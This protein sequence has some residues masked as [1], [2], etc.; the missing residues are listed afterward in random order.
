MK[1][2]LLSILLAACLLVVLLPAAAFAANFEAKD[3]TAG[4]NDG[5]TY[6]KLVDGNIETKW[7]VTDFKGAYI[8]FEA[9]E[10]MKVTGYSITTGNDN[11]YDPG[12]N[13]KDWTL[14]GS[15]ATEVPTRNSDS[16]E[17]IDCVTDDDTLKDLNHATYN[18]YLKN[19]TET[20]RYFKL[21]ITATQGS[22]VMQMSEFALSSCDH[23][24]GEPVVTDP[25]CTTKGYDS[26]TCTKCGNVKI[27]NEKLPLG[28]DFSGEDEKCTRCDKTRAELYTFD[29]SEGRVTITNDEYEGRLM[30]RYGDGQYE[31]Y[32]DPDEVITVIGSTTEGELHVG[33]TTPV[34][35]NIKDLVIDRSSGKWAYAMSL[36]AA[37]AN[38]TLILDGKNRIAGGTN[39]SGI[40]V[41]AD[42][43]L[44]IEGDGSLE[45]TGGIFAA[46]IGGS[47]DGDCGTIII[48]SG[49]VT[50]IGGSGGASIGTG[51]S[52]DNMNH[53]TLSGSGGAWITAESVRGDMTDFNGVLNDKVYGSVELKKDLTIPEG[54]SLTVT[55]GATLTIPEDVTL[56]VDGILTNDGTIIN[57]GTIVGTVTGNQPKTS[58]KYL[59]ENGSEKTA[60]C[61]VLTADNIGSYGT[62]NAGWYVVRDVVKTI[63]SSI[64]VS[65]DVHL[66]LEDRSDFNV[67]FGIRVKDDDSDVNNGSANALSIYAQSTGKNM[68]KLTAG[69]GTS[70][71]ASIGGSYAEN[72]GTITI[73][74]GTIAVTAVNGAGIGGGGGGETDIGG[75]GG[76]I[77]INGGNVTATSDTGAGIGG[78]GSEGGSGGSGGII[79][80]TGGVV[81]ATSNRGAGI[82]V[83]EDGIGGTFRTDD[84]NAVIFASSISDKTNQDSWSGVIFEGSEGKVYGASVTPDE[85]FTIE[86]GKNLFIPENAKLII[87][88]ITAVNKGCV[89]VD[90]TVSGL[91]GDLYYPLTV[92]G[93]TAGGDVSTYLNK[94]YGK[95]GG[96]ITLNVAP[97]KGYTLKTL[98]VT[99]GNNGVLS[100]TNTD[101]NEYAFTMPASKVTVKAV[102]AEIVNPFTD[103][104]SS[105]YYYDAVLWAVGNGITAGT[106]DTTFSPNNPCTRAQAVTLLWRAAGCPAPKNTKMTFTD[107]AKGSY[108]YDAVLW[109]VENRITYGTSDTTFSPNA[110]C[111]RAQFTSFLWRFE[112]MPEAGKTNPFTDVPKDAYY[113]DA[114]LWAAEKGITYGTSDTTFSPYEKCTRAQ[115]VTFMYRCMGE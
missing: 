102:F 57:N 34:K 67:E 30:V 92:S 108:Y 61:T 28:H 12:R 25:T 29:V 106:S 107:V 71:E 68:G 99:N 19:P 8:I 100:V 90:G 104:K 72:G 9:S 47:A 26:L 110:T 39:R 97:P 53:G 79:T 42:A 70:G 43:T 46:G 74:G 56:T 109:A 49:T 58:V 115:T 48:N 7:C 20:Y 14:Y 5:E 85:D 103:V 22:K 80:I 59:D 75:Y 31:K 81:T 95:A 15:A 13:P 64:T 111:N 87:K 101:K 44:T 91:G 112:G 63:S 76:T 10:A 73:N 78:G 2:R 88:D 21:E 66:I 62:L 77:T 54:E 69:T 17:E 18:Y 1:K 24:W 96:T 114:V 4:A 86:N 83:G 35:I 40:S 37:E 60:D 82:G 32:V 89:Y 16:W 51:A 55:E 93:G 41:G 105:D 27:E 33:T 36:D 98:T 6:T 94:D 50:A 45:V 84:G 38:V 52:P 113:A 23:V 3:G 65:G 11:E